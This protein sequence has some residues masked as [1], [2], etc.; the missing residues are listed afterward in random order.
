MSL[1]GTIQNGRLVLDHG[2]SL[3]NGTRVE[4]AVERSKGGS[5]RAKSAPTDSLARIATRAV[6]TGKKTLADEHDVLANGQPR[7]AAKPKRRRAR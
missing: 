1:R 3:P 6:K 5:R 7:G 4:V 2:E